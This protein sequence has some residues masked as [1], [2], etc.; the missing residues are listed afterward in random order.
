MEPGEGSGFS[1]GI[2]QGL[3]AGSSLCGPPGM[4]PVTHLGNIM[5]SDFVQTLV[6]TPALTLSGC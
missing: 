1:V 6:W 3:H 5:G 4:M 2:L